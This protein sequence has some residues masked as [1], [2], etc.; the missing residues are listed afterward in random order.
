MR[1]T[2]SLVVLVLVLAGDARAVPFNSSGEK[3]AKTEQEAQQARV[4][5]EAANKEKARS[6]AEREDA[7]QRKKNFDKSGKPRQYR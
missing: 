4:K 1:F 6:A 2:L 7:R 5:K 3:K